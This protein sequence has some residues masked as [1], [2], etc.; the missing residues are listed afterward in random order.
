MSLT[1][2][3]RR[4]PR[5]LLGV[6]AFSTPVNEALSPLP[7]NQTPPPPPEDGRL[8]RETINAKAPRYDWTRDEIRELYNTPLMELAHNSVST[9][10][11][12]Q[13]NQ[14]NTPISALECHCHYP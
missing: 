7:P 1:V 12:T 14:P 9:T 13:L 8:L 11:T 5:S 4:A 6:R 10:T 3:A 2:F